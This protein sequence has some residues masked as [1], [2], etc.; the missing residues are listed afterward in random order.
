MN[1]ELFYNGIKIENAAWA[2]I[3]TALMVLKEEAFFDLSIR[4]EP[5]AGPIR[6]VV[7]SEKGNY[8]PSMLV[9][10][11]PSEVKVLVNEDG[12]DKE[13]VPIGGYDV[14]AMAVTQDFDLIIRMVK[15]FYETGNVSPDLLK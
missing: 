10:G 8:M 13:D 3:E 2:D 5:E 11:R 14:D 6:L 12:R 1:I 4:P 7:E 15:E 9:G